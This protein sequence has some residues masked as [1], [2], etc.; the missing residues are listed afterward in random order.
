MTPVL[1][2]D[3]IITALRAFLLAVLPDGVE[4]VLGQVNR[5]PEPTSLDH[6]IITPARR[7][8][9]STTTHSYSM[10]TGM[11]VVAR[12][13]AVHFQLDVYGPNSTDNVQVIATLFRDA[14]GCDFLAP[15]QVQPLYCDD[16]RQMPLVNGEYQYEDRW[17]MTAAV[18]ANPPVAVPVDFA[19]NVAVNMVEVG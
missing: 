11:S 10:A 2:D 8:Q 16:G 13:N 4:V 6:V 3:A 12:S 7:E 19:A 14:W 9:L 18:Q 1:T 5:V 15:Y 17:T